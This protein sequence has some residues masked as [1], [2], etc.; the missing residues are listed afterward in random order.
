[1]PF[2]IIN[3]QKQI[4]ALADT[5]PTQDQLQRMADKMAT[6]LYVVDG[7]DTGMSAQPA[8]A[9]EP[10][11]KTMHLSGLDASVATGILRL[12]DLNL[13]PQEEIISLLASLPERDRRL[14][15]RE[16]RHRLVP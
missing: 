15:A 13:D 10:P 4:V 6:I 7:R 3:S 14:L 11:P 8:Q 5:C 1:M 9:A 16:L 12:E 2:F